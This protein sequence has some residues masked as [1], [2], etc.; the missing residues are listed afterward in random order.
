MKIL[1]LRA[2]HHAKFERADFKK[3]EKGGKGTCLPS[4][5]IHH[6][7]SSFF[8]YMPKLRKFIIISLSFIIISLSSFFFNMCQN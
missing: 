6:N 1:R 3:F 5:E 4:P 7:Q 2:Y 8:K